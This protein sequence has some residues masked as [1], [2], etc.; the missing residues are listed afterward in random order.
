FQYRTVA[1]GD[2]FRLAILSP[3]SGSTALEV[4]LVWEST[5]YPKRQYAC[6]S[7][8]WGETMVRDVAILCDGYR[9]NITRNLEVALKSLRDPRNERR[10]WIDQI[11]IN[12]EDIYER[13]HQVWIMKYI[14]RR[15][16][17]VV[18][19]LGEGDDRSRKLF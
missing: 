18:V 9:L 3:G 17:E 12:Q 5:K 4:R 11:C 6:L 7:Y 10:I 1:D 2:A 8:C 15:A 13:G 14:F 19:F 16:K